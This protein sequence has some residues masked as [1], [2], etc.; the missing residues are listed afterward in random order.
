[1]YA[2]LGQ[3]REWKVC[4][5]GL[6]RLGWIINMEQIGRIGAF[7]NAYSSMVFDVGPLT[8]LGFGPG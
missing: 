4:L 2:R 1:M 5:L 6:T 7:L 3:V 8:G